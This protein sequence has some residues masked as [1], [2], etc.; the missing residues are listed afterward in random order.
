MSDR[1]DQ[2]PLR[3]AK[4]HCVLPASLTADRADFC[5]WGAPGTS[6]NQSIGDVEAAVVA[7][8]SRSFDVVD[9]DDSC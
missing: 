5:L 3:Y 6:A 4:S 2:L 8:V 7:Y 9:R 1:R